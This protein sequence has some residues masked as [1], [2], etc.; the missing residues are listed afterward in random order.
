LRAGEGDIM[1]ILH[2][3]KQE[4]DETVRKIIEEH[5]KNGVVTVIDLRQDKDYARII[6]LVE[7]SDAVLCW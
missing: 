4:P 1:K 3:V 7:A 5:S 6:G 2:I